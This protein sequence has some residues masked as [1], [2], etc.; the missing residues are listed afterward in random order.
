M[1]GP[2]RSSLIQQTGC[3]HAVDSHALDDQTQESIRWLV[4]ALGRRGLTTPALML[5]EMATPLGFFGE[6]LLFVLAPLLPFPGSGET[7]KTLMAVLRDD[8]SRSLL[9]RLLQ[10]CDS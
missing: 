6:Q 7:A 10:E 9:Q 5:V 8:T 2:S 3:V 4:D 1:M